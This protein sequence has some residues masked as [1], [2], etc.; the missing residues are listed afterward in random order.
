MYIHIYIKGYMSLLITAEITKS[1][2]A[3]KKIIELMNFHNYKFTPEIYDFIIDSCITNSF[4]IT[5]HEIMTKFIKEGKLPKESFIKYII[6][7]DNFREYCKEIR[8]I[9]VNIQDYLKIPLDFSIIEPIVIRLITL[10]K[11]K[12]LSDFL[13]KFRNCYKD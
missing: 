4:P 5:L 2:T 13:N 11:K 6:Y 10:G 3:L 9:T 12:D 8:D 7:I 1:K